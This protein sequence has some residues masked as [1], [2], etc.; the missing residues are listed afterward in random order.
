MKRIWSVITSLVIT[1]FAFGAQAQSPCLE[2]FGETLSEGLE[3]QIN[4]GVDEVCAGTSIRVDVSGLK[5][6]KLESVLGEFV[7][8]SVDVEKLRVRNFDDVGNALL[9]NSLNIIA[10]EDGRLYNDGSYYFPPG[11]AFSYDTLN[12]P[13]EIKA[14]GNDNGS[15]T[16]YL[17]LDG[18]NDLKALVRG[19][20]AKPRAS[21]KV[22]GAYAVDFE[23]KRDDL[24]W[25]KLSDLVGSP[26][27]FVISACGAPNF[28][29][30]IPG[31]EPTSSGVATF[32][33]QFALILG[34]A[35]E[36]LFSLIDIGEAGEFQLAGAVDLGKS[37]GLR[38]EDGQTLLDAKDI[39]FQTIVGVNDVV[40]IKG[41]AVGLDINEFVPEEMFID[42]ENRAGGWMTNGE[43][44]WLVL[45][46]GTHPGCERLPD[47]MCGTHGTHFNPTTNKCESNLNLQIPGQPGNICSYTWNGIDYEVLCACNNINSGC[48]DEAPLDGICDSLLNVVDLSDAKLLEGLNYC[49]CGNATHEGTDPVTG[50]LFCAANSGVIDVRHGRILFS[51]DTSSRKYNV[52]YTCDDGFF[53][54]DALPPE[55]DAISLDDT[56][57]DGF[58]I[59][60]FCLDGVRFVIEE[61]SCS[62]PEIGLV[63][64]KNVRFTVG[65]DDF[66][67]YNNGIVVP[68]TVDTLA[69][70]SMFS[71]FLGEID[72]EDT[73]FQLLKVPEGNI[74][75]AWYT[76]QLVPGPQFHYYNPQNHQ[77]P[78]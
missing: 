53:K 40:L 49:T 58:S 61:D 60:D 68:V 34:E 41:T 18:T 33:S 48:R 19:D 77:H 74:L 75:F 17:P 51:W 76:V 62:S 52:T 10:D 45:P 43:E 20:P 5:I 35:R 12:A 13:S 32:G 46:G 42:G 1:L 8:K 4:Q 47:Y 3:V 57:F 15:F 64:F 39:T 67:D 65:V 78:P 27:E 63:D 72:F 25:V 2:V 37:C 9:F 6:A 28:Y 50:N 24:D 11:K 55:A 30:G 26:L 7:C 44:F 38:S 29:D 23:L 71:S 31:T 66:V 21:T 69:G 70:G 16:F 22:A 14:N 56:V 59:N 36:F 54:E 73:V